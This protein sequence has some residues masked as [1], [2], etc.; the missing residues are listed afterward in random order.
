METV[1]K[2]TQKQNQLCKKKLYRKLLCEKSSSKI[3]KHYGNKPCRNPP[4]MP[5]TI[6]RVKSDKVNR[7]FRQ[8]FFKN[9]TVVY[10]GY[11][12]RQYRFKGLS[13]QDIQ[14]EIKWT[15]RKAWYHTVP[16][17][18][19]NDTP[20]PS[21][22]VQSDSISH[23]YKF[24]GLSRQDIPR[25]IKWTVWKPWYCTVSYNPNSEFIPVVLHI[26]ERNRLQCNNIPQVRAAARKQ[27]VQ[28]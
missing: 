20:T 17:N 11:T 14:R 23:Q 8:R 13:R 9:Y 10:S 28:K 26:Q 3:K 2:M 7:S 19:N 5:Y 21:L 16:C 12:S 25:E 22:V 6:N 27:T 18:P 24:K 1:Q 4:A 15:A